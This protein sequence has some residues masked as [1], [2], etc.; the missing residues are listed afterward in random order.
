VNNIEIFV[1]LGDTIDK[2]AEKLRLKSQIDDK[3][4]YIRILDLKLMNADFVRNAPE[5]V[6]RLEQDKKVQAQD[7]LE[8]LIEKYNK[9]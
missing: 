2:E 4:D 7:Q 1:D 5:H 3:K 6:V 8:K 9:F